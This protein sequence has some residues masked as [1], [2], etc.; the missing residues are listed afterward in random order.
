MNKV[1][2]V[3]PNNDHTLDLKFNDGSLR[4]FDIKPY[5]E[6]EVFRELKDIAYFSNVSVAYGTVQ[7]P[8]E[9]DISPDTLYIESELLN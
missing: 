5:L 4:R 7:W 1:I 6:M 2:E 8:N 3:I 9:Q